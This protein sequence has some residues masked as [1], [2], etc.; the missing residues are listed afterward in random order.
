[1]HV[2]PVVDEKYIIPKTI[3]FIK[4]QAA[5]KK[6]FFVYVGYSEMHPPAMV[7][8]NFAGKSEKRGGQYA[9]LIGEMDLRVG[10]ILDAIK[11][12]GIDDNTMV[13]LTSD[14]GTAPSI[15][16]AQGGS[17]GPWR[18]DFF[19]PP[20][21]G[22]YRTAGMIRWPGKVPAEVVTD[23]MLAATDWLPT[24]AGMVGASNLVPKDR[25]IDGIDASAFMLGKSTTTGRDY[26]MFFGN[27]GGLMSVKWEIYKV[28]FRYA[29]AL[30]KPIIKPQFP[31]F[32]DLSSDPHED[33]NLFNTKLDNTWMLFPV[34]R[35]IGEYERSG[36]SSPA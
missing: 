25:P 22:C 7:N 34:L 27:D 32:Y 15:V 35:I 10:Q 14:N 26:Y 20:F 12:A 13:V 21:E 33:W 16:A 30:E 1:L 29:E 24:L 8:P 19:T 11:E 2:R 5:A 23:E 6:P 3:D 17:S 36:T 9:D 31:M 28:I 18:G 4:R